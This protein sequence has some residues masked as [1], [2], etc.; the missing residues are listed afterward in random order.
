MEPSILHSPS[1]GKTSVCGLCLME[2][3]SHYPSQPSISTEFK[4]HMQ[5][6]FC[7]LSALQIL[8]SGQGGTDTHGANQRCLQRF[9]FLKL[10]LEDGA[11]PSLLLSNCLSKHNSFLLLPT[12][13]CTTRVSTAGRQAQGGHG[14]PFH[15][16]GPGKCMLVSEKAVLATFL[17]LGNPK[18]EIPVD[19]SPPRERNNSLFP[20]WAVQRWGKGD[21]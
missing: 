4:Q 9:K 11:L 15:L 13:T 18:T 2:Q 7:F 6:G 3:V 1:P 12:L 20:P 17:S 10:S 19:S 14:P 8:W 21:L 5:E 16:A